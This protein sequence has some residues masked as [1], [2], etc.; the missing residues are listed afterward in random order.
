VRQYP[1]ESRPEP[2][3]DG[4]SAWLSRP[5]DEDGR[6]G[7]GFFG[8]DERPGSDERSGSDDH[9]GDDDPLGD[10]Q[11]DTTW[12]PPITA[13]EDAPRVRP[14]WDDTAWDSPL[15]AGD[16]DG[17]AVDEL[18]FDD[19]AWESHRGDRRVIRT[20]RRPEPGR[21]AAF[22]ILIATAV[23]GS[24]LSIAIAA[25]GGTT[26]AEQRPTRA[27]PAASSATSPSGQPTTAPTE[28]AATTTSA[29]VP[30]DL[31]RRGSTSTGTNRGSTGG[32][33]SSTTPATTPPTTTV[34][35]T[36]TPPTTTPPAPTTTEPAPPPPTTEEP[37]ATTEPP[38]TSEPSVQPSAPETSA[39]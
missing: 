11:A 14:A 1:G 6:S 32:G 29:A 35:P 12:L 9:F 2:S 17:T 25:S 4:W 30:P 37:P 18:S 19:E 16:L 27:L 21:R 3:D 31:A 33:G 26:P 23:A 10:T 24:G 39:G 28:P 5:S 7:G 36:T 8:N 38:A 13:W 34:P 15:S 20:H 22:R